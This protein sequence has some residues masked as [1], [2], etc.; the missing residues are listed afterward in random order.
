MSNLI[1]ER[2]GFPTLDPCTTNDVDDPL[3]VVGLAPVTYVS[4]L[5]TSWAEAKLLRNARRRRRNHSDRWIEAICTST[6]GHAGLAPRPIA[7]RIFVTV[8][9]EVVAVVGGIDKQQAQRRVCSTR[10]SRVDE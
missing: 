8:K 3:A 7:A 9:R 6:V 4:P 5:G 1:Y 2:L 10:A